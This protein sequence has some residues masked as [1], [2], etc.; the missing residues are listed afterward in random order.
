MSILVILG[1][2]FVTLMIIGGLIGGAFY[3][4][5]AIKSPTHG[6]TIQSI[7]GVIVL[8]LCVYGFYFVWFAP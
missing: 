4:V 8:A 1:K 6:K 2:I 7:S 3:I 5:T